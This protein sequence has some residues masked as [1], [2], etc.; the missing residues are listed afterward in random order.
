MLL[1]LARRCWPIGLLILRSWVTLAKVGEAEQPETQS[2]KFDLAE[3]NKSTRKENGMNVGILG[4]GDVGKALASGFLRHGH[5]VTLGTRAPA[6]LDDWKAKNP[7]GRVTSLVDAA[8]GAEL[9][10]AGNPPALPERLPKFDSSGSG[11]EGGELS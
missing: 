8:K 11:G 3:G 10:T 7:K 1:E 5:G 2:L 6:K 4:S 9:V